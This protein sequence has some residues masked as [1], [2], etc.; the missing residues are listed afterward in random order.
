MPYRPSP[1]PAG[2]R[3]SLPTPNPISSARRRRSL[4]T[5]T[6][7]QAD[8][9]HRSEGLMHRGVFGRPRVHLHP[10]VS[11][12]ENR[13]HIGHQGCETHQGKERLGPIR[14]SQ[15]LSRSGLPW[16]GFMSISAQPEFVIQDE[17]LSGRVGSMRP[18]QTRP[19][20]DC[21]RT[22][23]KRPGVVLGVNV[24]IYGSP[25]ECMGIA[26]RL[27]AIVFGGVRPQV[28]RKMPMKRSDPRLFGGLN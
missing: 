8:P 3:C 7:R 16:I 22:A 9:T 23:E 5:P 6:W 28:H 27:E 18:S 24:G 10:H 19:A 13:G 21:H 14:R 15:V 17:D 25:M 2:F 12:P 4:Q 20:W 11:S 1:A 26:S